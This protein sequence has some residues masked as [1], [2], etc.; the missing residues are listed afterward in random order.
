MGNSEDQKKINNAT[1]VEIK[2]MT[3]Y[4]ADFNAT[5]QIEYYLYTR[6]VPSSIFD[7]SYKGRANYWYIL[8]WL[9]IT[10]F[11]ICFTQNCGHLFQKRL[12]VA[13]SCSGGSSTT[14][15]KRS[16]LALTIIT[17]A[18]VSIYFIINTRF[19]EYLTKNKAV[20]SVEKYLYNSVIEYKNEDSGDLEWSL[21]YIYDEFYQVFKDEEKFRTGEL[22]DLLNDRDSTLQMMLNDKVKFEEKVKILAE[23]KFNLPLVNDNKILELPIYSIIGQLGTKEFLFN[24]TLE[25]YDKLSKIWNDLKTEVSQESFFV[26]I[27]SNKKDSSLEDS[28]TPATEKNK[29]NNPD[30][31]NQPEPTYPSTTTPTSQFDFGVTYFQEYYNER[32]AFV[33][34]LGYQIRNFKELIKDYFKDKNEIF[35]GLDKLNWISFFVCIICS[36]LAVVIVSFRIEEL[37]IALIG[38]WVPVLIMSLMLTYSAIKLTA[39]GG[40]IYTGCQKYAD[41]VENFEFNSSKTEPF[42]ELIPRE[43]IEI[44]LNNSHDLGIFKKMFKAC[45][46]GEEKNFNNELFSK[47]HSDKLKF[48]SWWYDH[49]SILNI[50]S[51]EFEIGILEDYLKNLT[52]YENFGNLAQIN[53]TEIKYENSPLFSL[54]YLSSLTSYKFARNNKSSYQNNTGN[55]KISQDQW[56][57]IPSHCRKPYKFVSNSSY[58]PKKFSEISGTDTPCFSIFEWTAEQVESRYDN[59]TFL[60]CKN[61]TSGEANITYADFINKFHSQVKAFAIDLNTSISESIAFFEETLNNSKNIKSHL[62]KLNK[63]LSLENEYVHE[64]SQ[65]LFIFNQTNQ[66]SFIKKSLFNISRDFCYAE[67]INIDSYF[68]SFSILSVISFFLALIL[69]G[70]GCGFYDNPVDVEDYRELE[71]ET[72]ENFATGNGR[73]SYVSMHSMMND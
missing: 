54:D 10:T 71:M 44:R 11:V 7:Y 72:I 18:F 22:G 55:C 37:K 61:Q 27:H 30:D 40:L 63:S 38:A 14:L 36:A 56:V 58:S 67:Q 17:C 49:K 35:D 33:V 1:L 29:G 21:D 16:L 6:K 15:I 65:G 51:N 42:F 57:L 47:M 39:F 3:D 45:G 50:P 12:V 23:K 9:I 13:N 60:D 24:K 73:I 41:F 32:K 28:T 68:Q 46:S 64:I 52:Q 19:D 2:N 20:Y 62:D 69:A 8:A 4:F 66:C 70:L 59:T 53:K 5:E 25:S 43:G 26:S 48:A 31:V 34:E